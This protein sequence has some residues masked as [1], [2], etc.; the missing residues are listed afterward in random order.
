MK[1]KGATPRRRCCEC[2]SWYLPKV[3]TSKTQRTCSKKCRLRRRGRSERERRG[4]NPVAAR[5]AERE[6][7]RR[8]RERAK[9]AGQEPMSRAGLSAKAAEMIEEIINKL[10]QKTRLSQA[11][12]R[13]QL[14]R[15]ALGEAAREDLKTGT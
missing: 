8:H 13:R 9:A 12:L 6:R 1:L 4:A 10:E 11:G 14:R 3:S 15:F 7:Q 2:R 5:E